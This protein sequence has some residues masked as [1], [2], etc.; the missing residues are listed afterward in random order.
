[1]PA[2]IMVSDEI[3][4]TAAG[5]VNAV[6]LLVPELSGLL[7]YHAAAPGN[8]VRAVRPGTEPTVADL[9]RRLGQMADTRM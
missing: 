1:M 3:P 6:A 7:H 5:A 8:L 4:V 9:D 2:A